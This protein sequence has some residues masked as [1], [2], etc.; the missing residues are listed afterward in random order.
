MLTLL[1]VSFQYFEGHGWFTGEV[2]SHYDGHYLVV[3]EDGDSEEYD[4][5][6][7]DDIVLTAGLEDVDI[8]SRVAVYRPIDD[9][10]YEAT[11]TRFSPEQNK[12]RPLYMKYDDG[13]CGWLDLC[14]HKFRILQ[15]GMRRRSE[16]YEI[17]ENKRRPE[18]DVY[19]VSS[20]D[21]IS[22]SESGSFGHRD[23]ADNCNVIIL[24]SLVR[25]RAS[26]TVAE[27]NCLSATTIQAAWRGY[28]GRSS[29]E[30]KLLN[31]IILQSIVRGRAARNIAE[32]KRWQLM[33][34]CATVLQ[35]AW[36]C[37]YGR[38]TFESQLLDII[39]LQRIVRGRAARNVSKQKRRQL[40]DKSATTIQSA[41]RVY[42][43]HSSYHRDRLSIIMVQSILRGRAARKK[44][45]EQKRKLMGQSAMAIQSAW[46]GY[47]AF[48]SYQR[49]LLDIIIVQIFVR[50][51]ASRIVEE[52]NQRLSATTIQAAWRGLVRRRAARKMVEQKRRQRMDRSATAIQTAW[53][54]HYAYSSYQH[55]LLNIV[56]YFAH[57][58]EAEQNR[59]ERMDLSATAIQAAWRGYCAWSS[60]KSDIFGVVLTQCLA[61]RRAA[62]NV[63]KQK[64][65][66]IEQIDSIQTSCREESSDG[67]PKYSIGTKVKKVRMAPT[68]G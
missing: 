64:R 29:Y 18:R 51:R 2:A 26:R 40:M 14:Q 41:W 31:I 9:R 42:C 54:G 11:V 16:D 52:Q 21:I 7:M 37:Y 44:V 45:A 49:T 38:L 59:R 10:W 25:R 15:G 46:R 5:Q 22:E 1:L 19:E 3:Y 50:C 12:R 23:K 48:S 57:C 6:E 62:R 53:R 61:R 66:L 35:A 33:D 47:S 55:A 58:R 43:L 32:Q 17:E 8:G 4:D 24:Q 20:L 27:L 67:R 56:Q 39:L 34:K 60:Y 28:Y 13:D 30:S 36:R 63:A 65:E 68:N